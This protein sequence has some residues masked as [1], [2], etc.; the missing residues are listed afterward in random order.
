MREPW[1]VRAVSCVPVVPAGVREFRLESFT[2]MVAAKGFIPSELSYRLS[3]SIF[4]NFPRFL[5]AVN[6]VTTYPLD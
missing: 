6:T 3:T 4:Y 1:P 2:F 5:S